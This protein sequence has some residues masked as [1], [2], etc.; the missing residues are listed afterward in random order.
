MYKF[1]YFSVNHVF[2]EIKKMGGKLCSEPSWKFEIVGAEAYWLMCS[3]MDML[4]HCDLNVW[5]YTVRCQRFVLV[6]CFFFFFIIWL[7]KKGE[8]VQAQ[9]VLNIVIKCIDTNTNRPTSNVLRLHG[10]CKNLPKLDSLILS[11]SLYL[12]FLSK[13]RMGHTHA[14]VFV[15]PAESQKR[16]RCVFVTRENCVRCNKQQLKQWLRKKLFLCFS[17][18][19]FLR[20]II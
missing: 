15:P 17:L 2:I 1:I 9:N 14:R 3:N 7:P 13:S 5:A 18:C 16:I 4:F 10:S 11:I 12:R 20:V 6:W 19:F 8:N